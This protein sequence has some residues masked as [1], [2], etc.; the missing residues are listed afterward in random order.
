[1][2]INFKRHSLTAISPAGSR[3]RLMIFTYHQ[4]LPHKDEWLPGSPTAS[5]FE[6]QLQWVKKYCNPLSL[7]EAVKKLDSNDLPARAAAFT[8]D[9]GYAN[10]LEVAAP[11]LKKYEIPAIIFVAVD[12]LERGIM[13]NDIVLESLRKAGREIDASAAGLGKLQLDGTNKLLILNQILQS[14]KYR[15]IEERLELSLSLYSDSS[16]E[17]APRQMLKPEDLGKLQEKGN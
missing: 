11:L 12:A 2:V 15:S 7:S 3:A 4:V 6:R 8:F 16:S 1:M 9:D 10:T 5:L 13:W 14:L 17:D